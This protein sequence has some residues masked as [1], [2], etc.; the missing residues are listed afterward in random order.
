MCCA[1]LTRGLLCAPIPF[2]FLPAQLLRKVMA[3]GRSPLE[4]VPQRRCHL[5]CSCSTWGSAWSC[6]AVKF[7]AFSLGLPRGHS[8][9]LLGIQ[10]PLGTLGQYSACFFLLGRS[11]LSHLF[12]PPC[13]LPATPDPHLEHG[14]RPCQLW[15]WGC[16]GGLRG[17]QASACAWPRHLPAQGHSWCSSSPYTT[18]PSTLILSVLH[19]SAFPNILLS[20]PIYLFQKENLR[21]VFQLTPFP[22]CQEPSQV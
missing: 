15:L 3:V 18:F 22:P 20:L 14:P 17:L 12:L 5:R 13:C 8:A 6:Y 7:F 2:L 9:L 11:I 4:S 1:R 16:N 21:A 19:P 10:D